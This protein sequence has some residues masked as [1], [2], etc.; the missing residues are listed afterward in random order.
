MK[1]IDT[2]DKIEL[3]GIGIPYAWKCP[4]KEKGLT[5]TILGGIH[6]N[7]TVGVDIVQNLLLKMMQGKVHQGV[8]QVALGN[9][10]AIK[11]G[12]RFIEKDLNRCF[13]HP[14]G[15]S[16][17]EV[18]ANQLKSLLI[19]TDVLLDIHGTI[20]PSKP[21]MGSPNPDHELGRVLPYIG[22][23]TLITGEGYATKGNPIYTDAFVAEAGGLGVTIEAGWL[24]DPKI[25]QIQKNIHDA[26]V[27]LGIFAGDKDKIKPV[28]MQ[29]WDAYWNVIAGKNFK[30]TKEW[31]NFE[32]IPAG[33]L[34]ATDPGEN[35]DVVA[36]E[37][38]IIL[39]PKS[40]E[41][42]VVGNEACIIA[43]K[44]AA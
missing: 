24:K 29:M 21:F 25:M 22:L 33:T 8:L 11:Q 34:I 44:K 41:N 9:I 19:D 28:D 30:F 39:F 12:K 40:K 18:R 36:S 2:L 23:S 37:A 38:S 26:L 6:G 32:E 35:G 13:G 4:G 15:K 14:K 3:P 5:V 16:I 20:K 17:E 10:E 43:R 31:Q 42:L 27:M 7:E 1:N